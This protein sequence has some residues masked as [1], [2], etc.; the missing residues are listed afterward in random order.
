VAQQRGKLLSHDR[1][2]TSVFAERT[3]KNLNFIVECEAAGEDVHPITQAVSALLGVVVFPW[4]RM[5]LKKVSTYAL[6]DLYATGWPQWIMIG[7]ESVV[8]LDGLIG[9][10]R[11]AI[12]H[13]GIEFDSDSR[14]LSEVTLVLTNRKWSGTITCDQLVEFCRRFCTVIHSEVA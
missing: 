14:K 4:E 6:S 5:A 12:S 2:G 7:S 10:L 3:I 8:D 11:H 9:N 13:G 1:N